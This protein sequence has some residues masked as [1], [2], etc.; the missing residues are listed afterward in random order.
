MESSQCTDEYS[1][2]SLPN[3]ITW[4]GSAA[5]ARMM[6]AN[7]GFWYEPNRDIEIITG[8]MAGYNRGAGSNAAGICMRW[9]KRRSEGARFRHEKMSN[10][11]G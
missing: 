8:I 1:G 3:G 10:R 4:G 11:R 6:F 9:R 2:E 7:N 5:N